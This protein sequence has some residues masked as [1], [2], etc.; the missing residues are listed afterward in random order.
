MSKPSFS[1]EINVLIVEDN[2]IDVRMI[3]MALK[4]GGFGKEPTVV[5]DGLP[6]LAL[7]RRDEDYA[8]YPHPDL[9]I[10]D[11]N[12]KRVDG[13]E[14][15]AHIRQTANLRNLCVAILSSSPADVM[16]S[17]AAA[18]NGYFTKPNDLNGLRALGSE[19]MDC[20]CRCSGNLP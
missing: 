17:R 4:E 8:D 6:A 5:D 15:L 20:Y 9:V 3:K 11:L 14:V 10:L 19:I 12:L 18:A 13:P 7:L 1:T 2:P 16:F